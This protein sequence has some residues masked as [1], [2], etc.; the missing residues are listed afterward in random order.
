MSNKQLNIALVLASIVCYMS[1]SS[2]ALIQL[3]YFGDYTRDIHKYY[4]LH[5][6]SRVISYILNN[7]GQK[8]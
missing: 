7:H 5:E 8:D 1:F 2:M 6:D 4:G 3:F